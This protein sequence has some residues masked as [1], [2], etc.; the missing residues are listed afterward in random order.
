MR[1]ESK[2]KRTGK[3]TGARPRWQLTPDKKIL[4]IAALDLPLTEKARRAGISQT[5]FY[6]R[7]QRLGLNTGGV[8][9]Q[10]QAF[11]KLVFKMRPWLA[12]LQ[13]QI[14][15][16]EQIMQHY[17]DNV[18]SGA[19]APSR[20]FPSFLIYLEAELRERPQWIPEIAVESREKKLA[21]KA[22][23]L[24]IRVSRRS[25]AESKKPTKKYRHVPVWQPKAKLF[26]DQVQVTL[27]TFR[28]A[29]RE[30][31]EAKQAAPL[32]PAAWKNRLRQRDRTDAEIEAVLQSKTPVAAAIRCAAVRQGLRLKTAQNLYYSG[33]P[34]A[35]SQKK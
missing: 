28:E 25:H 29:F 12:S 27:P 23:S 3:R 7:T 32:D 2:L 33:S 13:P 14:P 8:R 10:Q 24:G 19:L 1:L 35:K 11:V 34:K 17:V 20:A 9:T 5:A 4:E 30:L 6:R 26:Y 18:R 22:L 21:P 15:T 31:R 16:I